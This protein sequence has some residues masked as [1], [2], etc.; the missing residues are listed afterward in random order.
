MNVTQILNGAKNL[1]NDPFPEPFTV[2][3]SKQ[4]LFVAGS[5]WW[6]ISEPTSGMHENPP[7]HV[8]VEVLIDAKRVSGELQGGTSVGFIRLGKSQPGFHAA[9]VPAV[10]PLTLSKG[11]HTVAFRN[12]NNTGGTTVQ[13]GLCYFSATLFDFD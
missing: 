8:G 11:S 2:A 3:N 10:F 12:E 9:V 13:S 6:D 5:V 7:D 4:A 1:N